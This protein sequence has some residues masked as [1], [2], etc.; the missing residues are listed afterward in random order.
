M[1][2]LIIMRHA[3]SDWENSSVSDFDRPLNER[4]LKAATFMGSV[5][6]EKNK[7]PDLI[8]SSPANRAKTTAKLFA[9]TCK[10]PGE[11]Q[12][13]DELYFGSL[14]E[15]IKIVKECD[16]KH[17]SIMIVGHN[18][19]WES[20]VYRLLKSTANVQMPTAAIASL[21]FKIANWHELRPKTGELE[22]LLIPK[23]LM[24]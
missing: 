11:I 21:I 22:F 4:G 16:N 20:L 5:V 18:P 13:N 17:Q 2:N 9:K 6:Q 1:K 15:I 10:Y 19:T 8:L 12:Y 23:E 7:I 24:S 14:D 3:K